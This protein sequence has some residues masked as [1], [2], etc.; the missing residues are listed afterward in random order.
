MESKI[1][2]EEESLEFVKLLSTVEVIIF[3][4]DTSNHNVI[5]FV[6]NSLVCLSFSHDISFIVISSVFTW[7][8]T[9]PKIK[10]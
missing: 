2:K 5:Q 8:C 3:H 4:L 1:N 7:A 9:P 6:L 10:I